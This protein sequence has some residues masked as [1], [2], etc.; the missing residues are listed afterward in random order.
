MQYSHFIVSSEMISYNVVRFW[1]EISF[2]LRR[3]ENNPIPAGSAKRLNTVIHIVLEFHMRLISFNKHTLKIQAAYKI[4]KNDFS[5]L[6]SQTKYR[7]RKTYRC[8][9]L[10]YTTKAISRDDIP[11]CILHIAY[12][13]RFAFHQTRKKWTDFISLK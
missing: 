8:G 3:N 4:K 13:K 12:H 7:A 5:M 1:Q 2:V 6:N 10:F 11:Y 9:L